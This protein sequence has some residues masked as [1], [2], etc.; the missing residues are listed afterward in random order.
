[1]IRLICVAVLGCLP[2][3]CTTIER[4]SLPDAVSLGP[5]WESAASAQ[6]AAVDHSSWDAFL[7]R[8]LS[9]DAA[10]INRVDY[11]SVTPEDQANLD[12][13][14]GSLQQ[15]QTT[16]LTRDQQLAFWINLYN[17]K[18]VDIVLDAYPVESI[19]KIKDGILPTGPWKRKVVTVDGESLSLNDIEHRIIR[20]VFREARIHYA[21]NCAAQ[22]CPNLAPRA[23]RAEGLDQAFTEAERA[24][25]NDPRGITVG[26]DGTLTLSKIYIWFQEDFGK[27]EAE[28]LSRLKN[29]AK[30]AL[31]EK[32]Q[33]RT[34]VDNYVYDWALNDA[35]AVRQP[36][37]VAGLTIN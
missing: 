29:F 31:R 18:T 14:L 7:A 15:V 36:D 11:G 34:S 4:A 3:A 27:N 24:Y 8:Y 1:M 20:P 33:G 10:G 17:A 23:W 6:S 19:L 32:L 37:A 30:P 12:A 26:P 2:M 35:A 28:V 9:T 13:Y 22:S 21:L 25:V 16:S 5:Q